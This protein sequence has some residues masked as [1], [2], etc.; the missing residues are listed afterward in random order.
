M[1]PASTSAAI[2]AVDDSC[3]VATPND[4]HILAFDAVQQGR[5][6]ASI[7]NAAYPAPHFT[8]RSVGHPRG[9][10]LRHRNVFIGT[11]LNTIHHSRSIRP[12]SSVHRDISLG[13]KENMNE[14]AA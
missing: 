12:R 3:S 10:V 13:Y 5:S 9:R 6:S 1:A 8:G 2:D 7:P 11:F 14:A 4:D